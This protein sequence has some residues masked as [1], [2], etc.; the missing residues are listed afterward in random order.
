MSFENLL[1]KLCSVQSSIVTLN[2]NTGEKSRTWQTTVENVPCRLRSRTEKE[3]L[4][5]KSE[6]VQSAHILYIKHRQLD[7]IENRIIID[8][9][10]YNITGISDMGSEGR[11][12]AVYLE[13]IR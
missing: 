3:M 11:Y 2:T 4:S 5:D 9:T 12:L 6:Y 8:G 1:N 10:T 7:A 13:L